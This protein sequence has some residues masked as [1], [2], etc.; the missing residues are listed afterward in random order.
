M[1]N[2]DPNDV[3]SDMKRDVSLRDRYAYELRYI[4]PFLF[5]AALLCIPAVRSC[6]REEAELARREAYCA[7][8]TQDARCVGLWS[9][10]QVS[11]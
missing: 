1:N 8:H 7:A 4:A 3:D 5:V 10:R 2:R 9:R 11:P 6:Q